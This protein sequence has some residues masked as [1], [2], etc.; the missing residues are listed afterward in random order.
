[1]SALTYS[2]DEFDLSDFTTATSTEVGDDE[3]ATVERLEV[4]K[5]EGVYIG[6]GSS[7]NPLQAEGSITGDIQDGGGVQ[8]NGKYRLVVLNSQN[9]VVEGGKITQGKID[10]LRTSR[11]NSVDG[12]IQPFVDME[13]MEPYKIGLQVKLDSGSATYSN[14]NSS[15]AADGFSG[16]AMN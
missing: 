1:M 6:Q 16:E 5:G 3:F 15:F 8:L 11:A 2:P 12:E 7:K 9:N 13:V 14:A 4:E 10:S